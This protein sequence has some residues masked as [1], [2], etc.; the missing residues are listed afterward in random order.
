MRSKTRPL[1]AAAVALCLA[2]SAQASMSWLLANSYQVNGKEAVVSMDAAV[3]ESLFVFERALKLEQI[4]I[5]APDGSRLEA[6]QRTAARHRESFELRLTQ[7]GTYR[8]SHVQLV[9][10]GSYALDG[11]TRRFRATP[12]TLDQE[13]PA[14]AQLQ[15]LT[16]VHNR[17]QVFVSK[18]APGK[19]AFA[20]E[21]QGLELLPLD[22]VTEL[23]HGDRSRFRL[24]LDGRPLP[25]AAVRLL[26]EG[27]RYRYKL[28][29]QLIR[30][31]TKGEFTVEWA[32]A[33]RYW[34]GVAQGD[35]PA[36]GVNG[37]REEPLRR[38]SL[39]ASFEVLPR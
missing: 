8:V 36:Q 4:L 9:L 22:P 12:A 33:G 5:T 32:E 28:G 3:S 20:P 24:L 2:G 10:M 15:G 29:E 7:D 18:E 23:S 25:D 1:L 21:G 26:R 16:L 37:T 30:T 39:S 6:Q 19:L 31:D 35:K 17:Q 27:N 13:L 14:G 38:A 11:Q 34:L